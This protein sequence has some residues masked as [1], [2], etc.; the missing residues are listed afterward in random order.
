MEN[1]IYL[2]FYD[3]IVVINLLWCNFIYSFIFKGIATNNIVNSI[4]F[5]IVSGEFGVIQM[6]SKYGSSYCKS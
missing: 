5:L 4:G 6:H 1:F 2:Q 3:E